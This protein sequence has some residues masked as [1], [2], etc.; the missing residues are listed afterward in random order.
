MQTLRM[1]GFWNSQ[2]TFYLTWNQFA[3]KYVSTPQKKQKI[4]YPLKSA[5]NLKKKEKLTET[6]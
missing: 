4:D 5:T 3:K 6:D 2:F 1:D